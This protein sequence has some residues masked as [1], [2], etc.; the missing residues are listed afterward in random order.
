MSA[1]ALTT[2]SSDPPRHL[3][4]DARWKWHET[5]LRLAHNR[6]DA[7]PDQEALTQYCEA[8]AD[9]RQANREIKMLQI[10]K[11]KTGTVVPGQDPIKTRR[12]YEQCR[13]AMDR[14][15]QAGEKLGLSLHAPQSPP[16]SDYLDL[17]KPLPQELADQDQKATNSTA[18]SRPR[19]WTF[20]RIWNALQRSCGNM[21]AAARLLSKTYGV[22]CA[23]ATISLLVKKYPQL[24][25]AIEESEVVL[26][27]LC[28]DAA[29]RSALAGDERAQYFM[30]THVDPRF[31][32]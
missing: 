10:S 18:P 12:F 17:L 6:F 9:I 15:D 8:W 29:V 1:N 2:A 31:K 28:C 13:A 11:A 19:I 32:T 5:W 27:E 26:L 16:W 21:A 20:K 30:L 7:S 3:N 4:G 23:P 14:F 22:N 25:E 24:R